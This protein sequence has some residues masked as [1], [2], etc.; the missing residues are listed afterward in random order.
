MGIRG[1]ASPVFAASQPCQPIRFQAEVRSGQSYVHPL[2]PRLDFKLE[3]IPAGWAIR[4]LPHGTVRPPHDAA[5]LAN[6]PYRSPTP[7]L[8]STDYAFRAQDAI[9]WNP[10]SFHFFTSAPQ[11]MQAESA[12]QAIQRQPDSPASGTA[13][14]KLLPGAAEGQLRILDAEIY[15]GTA[16]QTA[17]AATVASHLDQTAHRVRADP[18]STPLGRILKLR[19]QVTISARGVLANCR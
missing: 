18:P 2:A 13:L 17:A 3:A 11:T 8:L 16:D 9:A 12:Y 1:T 10:R 14:L 15:G 5:E 19:F 7:L 4:I 6:P